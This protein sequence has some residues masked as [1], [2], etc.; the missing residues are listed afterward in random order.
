VLCLKEQLEA[1]Q[2]EVKYLR[3]HMENAGGE[4]WA[5]AEG[6]EIRSYLRSILRGPKKEAT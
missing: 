5:D 2:A 1:L 6:H 4:A 3:E